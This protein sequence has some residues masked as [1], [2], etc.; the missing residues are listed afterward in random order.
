MKE[1]GRIG[2]A[3]WHAFHG[4]I[5]AGTDLI[6]LFVHGEWAVGTGEC[7]KILANLISGFRCE[8]I[9]MAIKLND[10]FGRN[11]SAGKEISA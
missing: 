5:K 3:Y 7:A 6:R 4:H 9:P 8:R 1:C 2:F 10:A 11:E